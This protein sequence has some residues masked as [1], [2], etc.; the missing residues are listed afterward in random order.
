[1]FQPVALES[2]G[3]RYDNTRTFLADLGRIIFSMPA[4]DGETAFLLRRISVLLCR[5]NSVLYTSVLFLTT[6]RRFKLSN[7]QLFIFSSFFLTLVFTTVK[8]TTTTT[9]IT[10]IIIALL[11]LLLLL[12]SPSLLMMMLLFYFCCYFCYLCRCRP[13]ATDQ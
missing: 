5:F 13:A 2:L 11:L 7:W 1:M 6:T 9:T 12:L 3:P 4:D 8:A 10:I